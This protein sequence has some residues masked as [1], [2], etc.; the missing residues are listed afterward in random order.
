MQYILITNSFKKKLKKF[1]KYF[2]GQDIID[3]I[4]DFAINGLKKVKPI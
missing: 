2:A 1:K 3:D 4:K